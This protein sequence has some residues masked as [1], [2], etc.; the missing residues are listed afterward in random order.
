MST[1]SIIY[2]YLSEL[3]NR[4]IDGID[5]NTIL[6]NLQIFTTEDLEILR[7][8]LDSEFTIP[9]TTEEAES[10]ITIKN[11]MDYIRNN[12]LI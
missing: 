1:E 6:S 4:N 11:I 5:E 8:W 2:G 12:L 9:I 3:I 7:L 10:W